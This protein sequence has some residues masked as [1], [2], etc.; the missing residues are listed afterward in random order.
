[1]N[2]SIWNHHQ[3][4]S[5]SSIPIEAKEKRTEISIDFLS[6]THTPNTP[7]RSSQPQLNKQNKKECEAKIEQCSIYMKKIQQT[8]RVIIIKSRNLSIYKSS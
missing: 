3:Q 2:N 4:F 5:F 7:P 6:Q 8:T 1:M